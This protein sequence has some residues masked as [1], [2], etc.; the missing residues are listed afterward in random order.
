MTAITS[1]TARCFAVPL[2]DVLVDTEHR[3]HSHL[4]LVTAASMLA[5]G[6]TGP[7]SARHSTER[8]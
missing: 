5:D 4:H 2:D 8:N 1:V 7:V 6:R 3:K